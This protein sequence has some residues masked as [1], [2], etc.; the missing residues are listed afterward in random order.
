MDVGGTW[1]VVQIIGKVNFGVKWNIQLLSTMGNGLF[2][3]SSENLVVFSWCHLRGWHA[4]DVCLQWEKDGSKAFK[5]WLTDESSADLFV[6]C[7]WF[8][9]AGRVGFMSKHRGHH[10]QAHRAPSSQSGYWVFPLCN[11]GLLLPRCVSWSKYRLQDWIC[12]VLA[13][14]VC[15]SCLG[16]PSNKNRTNY[17]LFFLQVVELAKIKAEP[18]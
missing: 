7:C 17:F 10:I 8:H 2:H 5:S 13:F 4:W 16:A 18:L 14:R 3:G 9:E 6:W 15:F 11:T 12:R 1:L